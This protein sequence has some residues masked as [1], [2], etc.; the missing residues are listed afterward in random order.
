MSASVR[1]D[2][3]QAAADPEAGESPELA[4]LHPAV[5]AP[6][7]RRV[8]LRGQVGGPRSYYLADGRP[9]EVALQALERLGSEGEAPASEGAEAVPPERPPADPWRDLPPEPAA[10]A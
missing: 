7:L 3:D 10:E 5:D 1:V 2:L 9:S 8:C 4:P 6:P